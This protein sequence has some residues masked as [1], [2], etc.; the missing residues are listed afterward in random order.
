MNSASPD[1]VLIVSLIKSLIDL[2]RKSEESLD[3]KDQTLVMY[4]E[5]YLSEIENGQE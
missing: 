3:L 1:W 2:L 4:L 5:D